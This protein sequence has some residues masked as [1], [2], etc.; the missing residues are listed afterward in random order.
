MWDSM[1]EPKCGTGRSQFEAAYGKPA[2]DGSL[3]G[4]R[5]EEFYPM[6]QQFQH[7]LRDPGQPDRKDWTGKVAFR[8]DEQ[9]LYA[10]FIVLDNDLSLL[11]F[12]SRDWRDNDN[13]RL[14]LSGESDPAKR[15][16]LLSE[17]DLL[18]IM[19]PTGISHTEGPMAAAASLGGFVRDGIET[20][21]KLASKVWAGGYTLEVAIPL[22]ELQVKAAPGVKLGLNALSDDADGGFRR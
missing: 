18:L 9:Y 2:L 1:D 6:D 16:E 7:I 15:T 21:I 20:K 11:D 14:M 10:S 22:S 13:L 8:W 4:L 5:P 3:N 19:T 12:T 17:K